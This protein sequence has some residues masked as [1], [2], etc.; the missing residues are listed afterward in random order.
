[1]NG[2]PIPPG[3]LVLSGGSRLGY[4]VRQD[5]LGNASGYAIQDA[6]EELHWIDGGFD[7]P[8][9]AESWYVRPAVLGVNVCRK[10]VGTCTCGLKHV[11]RPDRVPE[12]MQAPD[13]RLLYDC[14]PSSAD[15]CIVPLAAGPEAVA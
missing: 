7:A 14:D 11:R 2:I 8:H 15:G 1:M 3:T 5:T 10:P 6:R 9:F 13:G 12:A 4:V